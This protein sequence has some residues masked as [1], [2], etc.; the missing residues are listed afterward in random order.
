MND[1]FINAINC[2]KASRLWI[3]ALG[4][5]MINMYTPGYRENK[6]TFKTFMDTAVLEGLDKNQGQGKSFPAHQMRMFSWKERDI[7]LSE[8]MTGKD[9]TQGWENLNLKKTEL[10]KIPKVT[11]FRVTY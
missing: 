10:T 9:F 5:N 2:Q 6:M 7:F 1:S 3:D 4:E 8:E 11:L